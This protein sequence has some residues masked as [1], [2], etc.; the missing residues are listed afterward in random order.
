M[1]Y[2]LQF[3][4]IIGYIKQKLRYILGKTLGYIGQKAMGYIWQK[5]F[6]ILAK[7]Y[8]I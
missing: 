6:D 5:L 8:G 3:F 2:D 7:N 4:K 1:R